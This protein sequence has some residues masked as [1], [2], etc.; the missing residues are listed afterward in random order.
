MDL[1]EALFW[2][3]DFGKLNW[4]AGGAKTTLDL[5]ERYE[6]IITSLP[7][8]PGRP[9]LDVAHLDELR[10]AVDRLYSNTGN[11][12]KKDGERLKATLSESPGS[13]PALAA[14]LIYLSFPGTGA[15]EHPELYSEAATLELSPLLRLMLARAATTDEYHLSARAV[16]LIE[17]GYVHAP[18]DEEKARLLLMCAKVVPASAADQ[19]KASERVLEM[20]PDTKAANKACSQAIDYLIRANKPQEALLWIRNFQKTGSRPG[21][22]LALFSTA[23]AFYRTENYGQSIQLLNE[24]FA[25]AKGT[26]LASRIMLGLSESHGAAGNKGQEETWLR[27]CAAYE[28]TEETGRS[29][30][31]TDNTR[32]VA[33]QRL[34]KL[35]AEREEWA[36]SLAC[37]LAWKPESWCGT[38]AMSMSKERYEQ[39]EKCRKKLNISSESL[40]R[41]GVRALPLES[42]APES[43]P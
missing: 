7:E 32:S 30:M 9:V 24:A 21:L 39:I 8:K 18:T 22:E 27:K 11:P 35:Y 41:K 2:H 40:L 36:K 10:K 16:P 15:K 12:T 25:L 38:C 23:T 3:F 13:V 37:W 6:S 19:A 31:D 17:Q 42:I 33:I 20:F 14:Y 43:T 34:G 4:L 29:L 1:I 28:Q 5:C 26:T